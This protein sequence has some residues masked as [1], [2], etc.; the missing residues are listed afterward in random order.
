[1]PSI[2]TSFVDEPRAIKM[3]ILLLVVT[4]IPMPSRRPDA[5]YRKFSLSVN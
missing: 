4:K 3:L 5:Y 2:L 1:M